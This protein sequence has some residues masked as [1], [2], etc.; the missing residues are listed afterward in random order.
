[1]YMPD[2]D[3]VERAFAMSQAVE[4]AP[5][6][7]TPE[8]RANYEM[9][10]TLYAFAT[11]ERPVDTVLG[12]VMARHALDNPNVLK[13]D[14]RICAAAGLDPDN[15]LGVFT[16]R[17]ILEDLVTVGILEATGA[18]E[19][20]LDALLDEATQPRQYRL[21]TPLPLLIERLDPEADAAKE[22]E[23]QGRIASYVERPRRNI[24][25][26]ILYERR[27]KKWVNKMKEELASN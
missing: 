2:L 14:S 22:A 16:V 27:S 12:G 1:M 8:G 7:A 18:V 19:G 17:Q 11:G 25:A 15:Y 26:S 9:H 10:R 6:L 20:S 24:I 13:T 21:K 23:V 4:Q 3:A 5:E